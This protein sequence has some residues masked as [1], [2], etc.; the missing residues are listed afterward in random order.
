[1]NSVP[2]SSEIS[3]ADLGSRE[4]RIGGSCPTWSLTLGSSRLKQK[5]LLAQEGWA[6]RVVVRIVHECVCVCV[7]ARACV[8]VHAPHLC[9]FGCKSLVTSGTWW[10]LQPLP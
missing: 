1:M 8:R 4:M 9:G 6:Q 10:S 2:L 5:S 3:W 7:S